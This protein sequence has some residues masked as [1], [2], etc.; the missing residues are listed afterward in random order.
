LDSENQKELDKINKESSKNK[1]EALEFFMKAVL[2][3]KLD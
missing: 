3:V 2:T 1:K